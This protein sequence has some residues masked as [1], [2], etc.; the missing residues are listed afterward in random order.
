MID[1]QTRKKIIVEY[2][3]NYAQKYGEEYKT[4]IAGRYFLKKKITLAIKMCGFKPG[5]YILDAGCANGFFSLAY[6]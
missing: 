1:A 4:T 5:D 3:D 2:Y 6:C